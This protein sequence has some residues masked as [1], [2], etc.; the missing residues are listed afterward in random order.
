MLF[1]V[2]ECLKGKKAK[3]LF[4]PKLADIQ[5]LSYSSRTGVK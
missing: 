4:Y 1:Q 3:A 2:A 5:N